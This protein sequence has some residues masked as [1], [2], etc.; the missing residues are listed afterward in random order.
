[1]IE[2]RAEEQKS[3]ASVEEEVREESDS[4][5]DEFEEEKKQPTPPPR[6]RTVIRFARRLD[7]S[8]TPQF[9][10][11]I[12]EFGANAGGNNNPGLMRQR[13]R[14]MTEHLNILTM[15][16]DFYCTRGFIVRG[17]D[18]ESNGWA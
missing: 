6:E 18:W 13:M 1:M 8:G 11:F 9:I 3:R 10:G 4:E 14:Q 17:D 12:P 2:G 15:F 16:L 7:G 5:E